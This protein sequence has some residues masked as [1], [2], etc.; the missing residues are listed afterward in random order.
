M[1]SVSPNYKMN[2]VNSSLMSNDRG[3]ESQLSVNVKSRIRDKK[4]SKDIINPMMIDDYIDKEQIANN[5]SMEKTTE[6]ILP[7][8]KKVK[9]SPKKQKN[10]ASR[11]SDE[12]DSLE[13]YK[14]SQKIPKVDKP[15]WR[16]DS[17]AMKAPGMDSLSKFEFQLQ[18]AQTM[19]HVE[20]DDNYNTVIDKTVQMHKLSKRKFEWYQDPCINPDNPHEMRFVAQP[21]DGLPVVHSKN[22][23]ILNAVRMRKEPGRDA[24]I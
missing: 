18:N 11:R 14:T 24:L 21:K 9:R 15:M 6:R 1:S 17:S 19:L 8:L 2:V 12:N 3:A 13:A 5:L 20:N 7:K 16:R 4:K 23:K 22:K 10:S